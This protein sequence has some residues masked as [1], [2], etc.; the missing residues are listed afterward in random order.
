MRK[1]LMAAGEERAKV[2]VLV[3]VYLAVIVTA[4]I[5]TAQAARRRGC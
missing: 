2:V 4:N 1:P 3:G 5:I